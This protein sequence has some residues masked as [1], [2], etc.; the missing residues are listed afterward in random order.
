[1]ASQ[2]RKVHS[3]TDKIGVFFK[4]RANEIMFS[5]LLD[6]LVWAVCL[7]NAGNSGRAK[8]FVHQTLEIRGVFSEFEFVTIP[9]IN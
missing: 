2:S 3:I 7:S 5:K 9:R 6:N 4:S 8:R 1:M